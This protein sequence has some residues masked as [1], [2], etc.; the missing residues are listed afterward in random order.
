MPYS[1]SEAVHRVY[2]P[3]SDD[4]APG[5]GVRERAQAALIEARHARELAEARLADLKTL[6]ADMTDATARRPWWRRLAG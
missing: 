1:L 5:N 4:S 6:L 3:A 2:A